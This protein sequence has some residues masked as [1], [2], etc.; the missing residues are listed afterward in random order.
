MTDTPEQIQTPSQY[1]TATRIENGVA[2]DISG[3]A[4]GSMN[5]QDPAAQEQKG[6][7]FF[8]Q[9]GAKPVQQQ[10]AQEPKDDDFFTQLG[11]RQ[12]Q[13]EDKPGFLKGLWD[14]VNTGLVSK[15]TFVRAMTGM[16]SEQLDKELAPY[17]DETPTH[18]AFREFTRGVYQDLG[19]TASSFT[20]PLSIATLSAGTVGKVPGAIG[21]IA[22]V[23]TGLASV[24]FT[25]QGVKD[26]IDS[27]MSLNDI[28]KAMHL[29]GDPEKFQ[30]FLQGAGIAV[31]GATGVY[32]SRGAL[33]TNKQSLDA[34]QKMHDSTKRVVDA[35]LH[36]VDISTKQAADA[37]DAAEKARNAEFDG[38]GTRQQVIEAENQASAATA[39]AKKA[40]TA[41]K[42][43]NEAH[44]NA[45]VERDR[46]QRKINKAQMKVSAK[47]TQD[48]ASV[49]GDMSKVA[50]SAPH[51][52]ASYDDADAKIVRSYIEDHHE[53][54]QPIRSKQDLFDA[55]D[56]TQKNMENQVKPYVNKYAFEPIATRCCK[57]CSR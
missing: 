37:I 4:L 43:A 52:P 6:D 24:G 47:Q 17:A 57:R 10:S 19:G 23:G 25:A 51:G 18:A 22:R 38:T 34:A 7:D 8:A 46:L 49:Y 5:D 2:Y 33:R 13:T 26:M 39:N 12:V 15:D 55:L 45:A 44:G 29:E 36:E 41:L 53:N 56:T 35:R 31:L 21:T 9:L 50:P 28:Q 40:Q 42:D 27:G 32:E 48:T 54:I 3:K 11:G 14:K 20:S 30:K 1:P 16:T